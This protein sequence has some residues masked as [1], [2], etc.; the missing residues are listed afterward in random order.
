MRERVRA[1]WRRRGLAAVVA[2]AAALAGACGGDDDGQSPST[3]ARDATT[4]S[5]A[6]PAQTDRLEALPTA[7]D[8]AASIAGPMDG[9]AASA[10]TV[11][12]TLAGA[13]SAGDTGSLNTVFV[14]EGTAVQRLRA[15]LSAVE[16]GTV[17]AA[18][19][20]SD[21]LTAVGH[22]RRYLTLL[23]RATAGAPTR[24]RLAVLSRARSE[25]AEALGAYR[26]F[27]AAVPVADRITTVGLGDTRPLAA[28]MTAAVEAAEAPPPPAPDEGRGD[29]IPGDLDGFRSPTGNLRCELRG[30]ELLCSSAN[31]GFI[32]I[33]G[34]TGG[35]VS[36]GGGV[37]GGPVLPYGSIWS[38]GAF[39]CQ[40][41]TNGITCENAT[42][43]GFFLSRDSYFEF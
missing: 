19:A 39:S 1:G 30:A 31:D 36:A 6:A 32:V 24:A 2:A 10:G 5:A 38:R 12:G 29:I 20:H 40:S 25:V 35:P 22:H 16:P 26:R 27:F 33:L 28:A 17:A 15:D 34:E 42:G 43:N 3:T 21:L 37:D 4:T 8:Y 18:G 14:R 7:E 41:Q 23:A 13:G 9:L 11:A